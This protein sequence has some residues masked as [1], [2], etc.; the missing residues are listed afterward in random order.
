[1]V[2]E[3]ALRKIA[4]DLFDRLLSHDEKGD[5]FSP[6]WLKYAMVENGRIFAKNHTCMMDVK[7]T[8][9]RFFFVFSNIISHNF[10]LKNIFF[11]K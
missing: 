4:A 1:M 5:L 8:K 2:D 11:L 6:F 9:Q 10:F 7:K 3:L